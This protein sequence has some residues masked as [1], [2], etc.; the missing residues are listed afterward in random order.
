MLFKKNKIYFSKGSRTNWKRLSPKSQRGLSVMSS[1]YSNQRMKIGKDQTP[2]WPVT[3]MLC[4]FG[5]G[6]QFDST[7]EN[8]DWQQHQGKEK[9]RS[10][11]RACKKNPSLPQPRLRG[12]FPTARLEDLAP[13]LGRAPLPYQQACW[14]SFPWEPGLPGHPGLRHVEERGG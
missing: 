6:V 12:F 7:H 11:G 3:V 8:Y 2:S 14:S 10:G 1:S 5:R 4:Q 13:Y 9:K